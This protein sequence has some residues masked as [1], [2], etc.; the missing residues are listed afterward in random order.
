MATYTVSINE[1]WQ[2]FFDVEANSRKEA[3]EKAKQVFEEGIEDSQPYY[4]HTMNEDLWTTEIWT[5]EGVK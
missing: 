2:R 1:V 5:A 4:S 3:I